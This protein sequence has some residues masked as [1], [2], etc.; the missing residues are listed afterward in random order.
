VHRSESFPRRSERDFGVDCK[1]ASR[2]SKSG[3]FESCWLRS[4]AVI[5]K[6]LIRVGYSQRASGSVRFSSL[7][8]VESAAD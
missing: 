1:F 6:G 3:R 2:G 7:R 5:D 4:V 8:F